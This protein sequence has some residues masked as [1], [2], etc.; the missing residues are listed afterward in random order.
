MTGERRLE[1]P[2][3]GKKEREDKNR[4]KEKEGKGWMMVQKLGGGR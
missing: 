2:R 1:N 3:E 4:E